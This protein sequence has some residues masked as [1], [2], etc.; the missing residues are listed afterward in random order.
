MWIDLVPWAVASVLVTQL[1]LTWAA[2]WPYPY[3]LEWMEGGMLAHA[4]RLDQGLPLYVAPNP[5][6]IPFIYPPGYAA[7]VAFLGKGVGLSM[8]L[9]RAVSL[10]GTLGAAAAVAWGSWRHTGRS[11]PGVFAAVAFLGTFPTSGAFMDLVRPDALALGFLAWAVVLAAER[12][13]GAIEAAAV[14]LCAAFLCKHNSA[15]FG[16]PIAIG[17]W[18]RDGWR[19]AAR[20]AVL[21]AVPALVL[22]GL[23]QWQSEGH[24]L[25]Y[26]LEVPASH[27]QHPDRILPGL[28]REL[29]NALPVATAVL[30][31]W[32]ALRDR[33]PA[34][35]SGLAVLGG[36]GLA[37]GIHLSSDLPR[38][39]L[40]VPAALG[41]FGVGA[42]AVGVGI[43]VRERP[44]WRWVFAVATGITA[45]VVAGMMRSHHGG[46]LNVYM[47]LHWAVALGFG[48][49]LGNL[50]RAGWSGLAALI[51][52][53]QL[54]FGA[55]TLHPDRFQPTYDDV[56]RGNAFVGWLRGKPG[57]VLSPFAAW[58]PVQA[59]HPPSLHMIGLWD[60][61]YS[62]GPYELEARVVQQAIADQYWGAVLQGSRPFTY[63]L[64]GSYVVERSIAESGTALDPK[65]GWPVRPVR[66]LVPR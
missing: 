12:W 11:G 34:W 24:F 36:I 39:L 33:G 26:L 47:P 29:G 42:A 46:Y 13:R 23:F 64:D 10:V 17:L 54:T 51:A 18:A 15:A 5:D 66:I 19:S 2:R 44:G 38:E 3:D 50:H 60:L 8:Q 48:L 6:F 16:V 62:G 40:H 35:V 49:V 41:G 58:I 53:A 25:R 32:L 52:A 30:G 56:E 43:E 55:L 61:A 4:W 28:P 14:L 9:G 22:V 57:P 31:A 45:L 37:T 20:F 21:S 65:S 1:V 59:G 7:L 63:P 27:P